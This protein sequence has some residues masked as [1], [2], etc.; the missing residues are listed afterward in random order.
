MYSFFTW[1]IL[2]LFLYIL[3]ED[4]LAEEVE[5]VIGVLKDPDDI[6]DV[7]GA[8][9]DPDDDIG[10]VIGALKDFDDDKDPDDDIGDVN[11]ELEDGNKFIEAA[12]EESDELDFSDEREEIE[13]DKADVVEDDDG[14]LEDKEGSR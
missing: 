2:K 13:A 11:G 6:G 12:T 10:D 8:L 5:H 4:E 7:I 1:I 3:E 14:E 9:K